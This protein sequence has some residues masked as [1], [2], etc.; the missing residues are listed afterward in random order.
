MTIEGTFEETGMETE[1]NNNAGESEAARIFLWFGC[2]DSIR[3][4]RISSTGRST[5]F[6]MALDV[7]RIN[8]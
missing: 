4:H 2:L 3:S 7:F 5:P 6:P 1:I 8:T